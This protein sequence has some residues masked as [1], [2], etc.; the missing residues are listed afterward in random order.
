MCFYPCPCPC[1]MHILRHMV[2]FP[3]RLSMPRSGGP[4]KRKTLHSHTHK[5][6]HSQNT[7]HIRATEKMFLTLVA[8]AESCVLYATPPSFIT[9]HLIITFF[10]FLGLSLV[11]HSFS[12]PPFFS[13]RHRGFEA[14]FFFVFFFSVLNIYVRRVTELNWTGLK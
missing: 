10:L 5:L 1:P 8:G 7:L 12:T 2:S 13:S 14:A 4:Q 11:S 6:T 3:L 9:H